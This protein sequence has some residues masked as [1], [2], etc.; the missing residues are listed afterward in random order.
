MESVS[1]RKSLD[2]KEKEVSIKS[3]ALERSAEFPAS[4]RKLVGAPL[5]LLARNPV[6]IITSLNPQNNDDALLW[7]HAVADQMG[8]IGN[9]FRGIEEI[10]TAAFERASNKFFDPVGNLN[11]W[12]PQRPSND[13]R[14]LHK[15]TLVGKVEGASIADHSTIY[16][17]YDVGVFII[18]NEKYQYLVTDGFPRTYTA[19]MSTQWHGSLHQLGQPD[20]DD[21][22][23]IAESQ[24]VEAEIRPHSDIHSGVAARLRDMISTRV[25]KDIAVYGP[26]I[27]DKGHCCH[28]EIHPAE[29]IWWRGDISNNQ[30]QYTFNVFC[31]ASARFW[32]RDQMDDSTKLK[33]WGAPPIKGLFAIAFE[34]ELGKP[35]VKFEVS[36]IDHYNVA[37]VQGGNQV[38]NLIYQ[39]DVLVTF[40]PHNDAFLVTYENVGF[41]GT[42]KVRGFLV[43]ETSVGSLRQKATQVSVPRVGTGRFDTLDFP[44]GIDVNKVDQR[45]EREVFEKLEGRY[46]FTV[47][48]TKPS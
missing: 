10:G 8:V 29:Q 40:I 5:I 17:D 22:R 45:F 1:V 33:P 35:A 19:L 28:S 18:P 30:K 2:A 9:D 44:L 41:V 32:W 39:N 46:T 4:L 25:S 24:M 12:Y 42:N 27:Y 16:E 14:P 34:A 20:C 13:D 26:W 48:E 23:S 38:Y 11:F 21:S 31:D 3:L 6:T 37:F 7:E 43:L 47:T 36:N 15:R